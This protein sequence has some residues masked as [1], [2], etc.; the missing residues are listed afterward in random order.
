VGHALH[1]DLAALLLSHPKTETRD[2]ARWPPLMR[3]NRHGKR[4]PRKLRELAAEH[5]GRTIQEGEH[6]SVED[7]S[8]AMDLYRKFAVE[9]EQ[10]LRTK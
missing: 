7:A 6:G 5:L 3:T 1:N 9:W 4:R 2:T 8:A 10:D